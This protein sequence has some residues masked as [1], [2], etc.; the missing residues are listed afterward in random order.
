MGVGIAAQ[1]FMQH[2][3]NTSIIE[4]DPAVYN[5]AR[6]NFGLPEP[7]A[8]YLEDARGWIS[9]KAHLSADNNTDNFDVIVHDCF[10]GGG[11][12]AQLYTLEFWEDLKK[13]LSGDGIVAVVGLM[14][15]LFE[16]SFVQMS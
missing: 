4:I 2:G 1:A 8:V 3:I 7:A 5:A 16:I 13:S 15:H 10:S 11:V 9:R 6:E 14:S 12:P